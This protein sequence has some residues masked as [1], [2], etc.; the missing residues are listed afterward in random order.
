MPDPNIL[1]GSQTNLLKICN[2]TSLNDTIS[3]RQDGTCILNGFDYNSGYVFRNFS[4][5]CY[6]TEPL[7][8]LYEAYPVLKTETYRTLLTFRSVF[9]DLN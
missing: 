5:F 8:A 4:I 2:L 7:A 1:H 3:R 6:Y 9:S